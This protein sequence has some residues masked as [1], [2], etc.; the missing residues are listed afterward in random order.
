MLDRALESK[1]RVSMDIKVDI[2]LSLETWLTKTRTLRVVRST[3][4][5]SEEYKSLKTCSTAST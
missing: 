1:I 3:T 2:K 4:R 5:L